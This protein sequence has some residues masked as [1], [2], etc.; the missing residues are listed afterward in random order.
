MVAASATGASR[1]PDVQPLRL[2][3]SVTQTL[4][5]ANAVLLVAVIGSLLG[6]IPGAAVTPA[7]ITVCAG[8]AVDGVPAERGTSDRS[9]LA[10]HPI[11]PDAVFPGLPA[12]PPPPTVY[13]PAEDDSPHGRR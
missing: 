10:F 5:S 3:L 11:D 12:P 4:L 13:P 7:R 2:T 9:E 8:Y 1:V 6:V